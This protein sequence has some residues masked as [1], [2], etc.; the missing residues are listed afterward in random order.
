MRKTKKKRP[1]ALKITVAVCA[2]AAVVAGVLFFL[3]RGGSEPIGYLRVN[4]YGGSKNAAD[5]IVWTG[6]RGEYY[7]FLPSDADAGSLRVFFR[8]SDEIIVNDGEVLVNGKVTGAFA[9][10]GTFTLT[11]GDAGYTLNVMQSENI[12][13][14]FITTDSGG[15]EYLHKSRN[16]KVPGRV[17][18]RESGEVTLDAKLSHIKM[19]GNSCEDTPEDYLKPYNIKF[20]EKRSL[21]GLGEAKKWA[22][23]TSEVEKNQFALGLAKAAGLEYTPDC[24]PADVY[25]DGDYRGTYLVCE[26]VQIAENRVDIPDLKDANEAANPG[27]DIKKRA[28]EGDREDGYAIPGARK[29]VDIPNDPEDISGGYLIELDTYERYYEEVSGFVS[30]L[31]LPIVVKSPEYASKAEVEYIADYWQEAEEALCSPDGNNS[32][33]VHYTEYFDL[34]SLVKVFIV[35]EFTMNCDAAVSSCFFYKMPNGKL[36]AGPVWDFNGALGYKIDYKGLKC[37]FPTYW[38]TIQR[39]RQELEGLSFFFGIVFQH[40]DFRKAVQKEWLGFSSV[41]LDGASETLDSVAD[42]LRASTCM[43]GVRSGTYTASAKAETIYLPK[44]AAIKKFVERRIAA[45]NKGFAADAAYFR[46]DPNGGTGYLFDSPITSAGEELE[47][48]DNAYSK[49]GAVFA[50][51]NTSADGSGTPYSPGDTVIL[52]AGYTVFYAQWKS[53]S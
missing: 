36:Y 51:W 23:I 11:C 17:V 47:L 49:V 41:Y 24:A 31:A 6:I 12:P 3:L 14:L 46:Y 8:S 21:L 15:M 20:E 48:P 5:T 18:V 37:G 4:P 22:L 13:S 50:G 35:Q 9:G 32:S 28:L 33:G 39:V 25:L 7:L 29:W 38:W 16:N 1:L 10:C 42:T 19:R 45:L 43:K 53:E 27:V 2:A 40:E 44:M 34:E 26:N 52:E 30:D